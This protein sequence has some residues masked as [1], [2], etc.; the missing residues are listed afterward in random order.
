MRRILVCPDSFKG[1]LTSQEAIRA[2]SDGLREAGFE[3]VVESC[4]M[5]DGGEGFDKIIRKYKNV[6]KIEVDT[7]DALDRDIIG[8]YFIDYNSALAYIESASAIGIEKL[9]NKERNPLI[10]SSR[11]LGYMIKDAINKGVHE[12]FISLGGSATVDAGMG[13]L[14]V[15][16]VEFKNE[17]NEILKGNGQNLNLITDLNT[18]KIDP[19]LSKVKFHAICDVEN[20]LLGNN[21]AVNVFAPQKGAGPQDLQLLES[22]MKNF[23]DNLI[24][25]GLA[26]ETD[27]NCKGAGAAGGLGFTFQPVFQADYISG[28]DFIKK[29]MDFEEKVAESDLI[30]TGEGCIDHQSLMGKVLS[31]ILEEAKKYKVPVVA[32]GGKVKDKTLLLRNGL[33]EAIEISDPGLTEEENMEKETAISHLK[34]SLKKFL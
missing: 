18:D 26:K 22:G 31:G 28:I 21:G 27:V 5:S 6:K 19:S 24:R 4:E 23:A 7:V 14:E 30:I 12:I 3:G 33:H 2:I 13:M 10:A 34:T 25:K 17:N 11:G 29:L 16:G 1:S 8:E 9:A 15:L 32:F 20:P